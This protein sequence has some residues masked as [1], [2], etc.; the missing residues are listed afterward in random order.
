M[1]FFSKIILTF[2]IISLF[3]P[4]VGLK[5]AQPVYLSQVSVEIKNHNQEDSTAVITWYTNLPARGRV[6]YGLTDS[7]GYYIGS[8]LSPRLYHEIVLPNMKSETTYHFKVS[9]STPE[10]SYIESFNQTFKTGKLKDTKTPEVDKVRALHWGATWAV[11]TWETNEPADSIV[12]YSLTDD[13][14][15]P[16]RASS[17]SNVSQH[18]VVI[19]NLKKNTRYFYK[20]LSKDKD[21]N[22]GLSAIRQFTTAQDDTNDQ[23]SL[24]IDRVSPLAAPDPLITQNTVTVKWHTNRPSKGSVQLSAKKQKTR[25]ATE[26]G[27]YQTDHQLTVYE[28]AAG[29]TYTMRIQAK[30]VFGKSVTAKDLIIRT[31]PEGGLPN[32]SFDKEH[33]ARDGIYGGY[34]RD[35]GAEQNQAQDLKSHLDDVFNGRIPASALRNWFVLVKAYVY[36]GYPLQSLTQAVKWGGKTVHPTIPWSVWKETADYKN[37]INR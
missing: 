18:E 13:L 1:N 36:G 37:Y 6:D 23:A 17:K 33:C 32:P 31:L 14:A 2:L 25:K 20:V 11:I 16:K 3:Y 30:D 29:T 9:A 27:Y 12:E 26:D 22:Q 8:S 24:V 7:Y 35:L 21:K 34:C 5:A 15:K 10:G 4:A 19:K 28:L